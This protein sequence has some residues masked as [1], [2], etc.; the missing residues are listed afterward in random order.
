MRVYEDY[1]AAVLNVLRKHSRLIFLSI[2]FLFFGAK[3]LVSQTDSTK[4]KIKPSGE[5]SNSNN[6]SSNIDLQDPLE[7]TWKYNPKTNQYDAYRQLGTL[8]YA[9]GKSLTITEYF[10]YQSKLEKSKYNR[11][12][13]QNTD[14]SQ[15]ITKG[16]ITDYIQA[17]LSNPAISKIFGEG[18]VDFQL[19]GSAMVKLGGTINEYRN[20]N[21]SK[22]QQRYFVPVFDQ[23]LQIAANGNIGEFVKLG[24]NYDTEAQF[25]FD[26]QTN[27]GWKGKPDGILKDVQVGNVNLNLPTQLIK[28]ANN[29]FGFANTMQFGKT[30]IKTVFSQNRGQSTETVLKGGAQMNEFK[31]SADNYDQNRH[32]FLSQFFRDNYDESLKNL[33]IVASGVIINR[34]EVWVTNRNANVETPRDILCFMDLGEADPYRD[35][36]GGTPGGPSDR[37]AND[38]YNLI[39]NN[40]G[41]RKLGTAVDETYSLFPYF[42]QTVDF[43]VLNY[44]RQLKNTEFTLNQ[45][46]GY[47]S[48]NQPLNND[49]I[50]AVAFEYTYNG[51]TYQVGEFSRDIPP[52]DQRVLHLKMLKGNTIRTQLPIWDLM[53][54]NIYSLNTYSLSLEDFKLNVIYA[55]DT[56]GADYNYLPIGGADVPALSE[57]QPLIRVLGLDKLN[58]QQEA[59]PDGIFDAIEGVT[60]QKKNARVI[61]P[62]VEPFGDFLR[63][64]FNGR[65][66]LADFYCY[67]AVY[68]STKFLAKQDVKHN[69]FFLQGSF[70]SSNGAELFLGTTNLQRG[71]VRVT[72]NGRP[73]QEGMDYE[74]DYAMGR[75]RIINQGLLQGG[76]EI[77]ASADGQSMFNIQQKTLLGG[78]IEHKYSKNLQF[79]GT[80]LHMYERPIT[81]KTNFNEEPLLNTI[82]G[83]DLAYSSKS[84]FLTKLIDKLPF[85]ETKEVSNITAY[86][87]FA[88]IIPHNH[89]SQGG[90][91][92]VSNLEDFE[93][94]ELQNDFKVVSNW[95]VASI[96]QKQPEL[97]PET[98]S[99]DKRTWLNKHAKLSFYT[100]D[101]LFYRDADMPSNIQTRVDE[102][103]SNPYMRQV[104]QR[105]VFPER[106]FPQGTPTILPTLDLAFDPHVRGMYNYNSDPTEIDAT[107]KLINPNKSWAGIMR[108]VDQNDFEAANIDYVEI[109]LMDP[110]MDNPNLK[111]ELLFHLGNV[112]EDILPD[113]RKAFENGLPS[114]AGNGSELDTSQFGF[115][116]TSPQINFAF[117]N[118]PTARNLQDVGLDGMNDEEEK[119]FFDTAYLQKIQSN[120]GNTSPLYLAA[121]QD[122]S[123]DN[124]VHYLENQYTQ[125]DADIIER[126]SRYQGMQ[127]NSSTA[128]FTGQYADMPKS[129]TTQ[130][131]YE[132]I[133]RDFTMNQSEDYYQYRIKIGA[134]D[135]QIGQNYVADIA[136]NTITLRNGQQKE[137]KWY[138]LKIPIREFEKAVGNISDFKSIRFMRM[139]MTGFNDL[140]VLRFGYINMVRADWRRYLNSL[141]TPGLVVPTDP[142]DGTKFVV[143]TVNLEENSKRSPIAY[144]KPPGIE[145]VQNMASL[146]TVLENEQSLSLQTCN[147]QPGDARGAFKT[148]QYDI[149]NYSRMQLYVH[150]EEVTPNTIED[151]EVSVFIRFGTDLTNNY[152]E[153]ELPL[154]MTRGF[155]T[156]TSANSDKLIWPDANFID[157]EF[158]K[159]FNLKVNRQNINW[160]MTAPFTKA[161]EKGK[162]SV[163]GLPDL[164][165]I[166]VMMIGVRNNS[167]EPKCFEVW[168]NELRVK[169]IANSGGW[170]ALANV[171][172]QLADFGQ[173]NMAGSI[174]TIGFGDVDKKLNDRSLTN[175]YN[176]DIATNLEFGK[177]FPAD[178][179]VSIP[180]YLGWSESFIRPKFNPLNP[181]LNLENYLAALSSEAIRESIRK[182]AEDYNSLFS[183]NINNFKFAR[184]GGKK[185]KPWSIS[186]FNGSYSYQSNYRRNQQ[187]EEFFLNTTQATLGY[188]YSN[189]TKFIR[190]FKKIKSKKLK[191]IRDFNFNLLPSSFTSQLQLNRL[192][193]E[194]QARNNNNFKQINP[195]LYDKNFTL[196]RNYNLAFPIARSLNV[197]YLANVEA[198]IQEPY[199]EINSKEKQDS[200]W[201]EF[202]GFGRMRRFYQ[203]T[204]ATYTFPFSKISWLRW[205]NGSATYNGSYE[206]NQAPPAFASLGNTIQNSQD[207][208]VTGQFNLSLLYMKIPWLKDYRKSKRVKIDPEDENYESALDRGKTELKKPNPLTVML[209][210]LITMVKNANVNITRKETT[211]LPGFAHRPDYFGYN[212]YRTEPGI[213]FVFGLQ[214]PNMR[215]NMAN[216]GSLMSD[217]RQANF[218][219]NNITQNISGN[220]TIE[221]LKDFR[222]RINFQRNETRG[223]QSIFKFDGN[224]WLDQGLTE[225]GTYTISGLFLNTHFVKDLDQNENHPNPVFDNFL[226]NRYTVATRLQQQDP[227]VSGGLVIDPA[228]GYP[229]GYSKS[230]QD[231]I[232]GGF[233]AAYSG[234]DVGRSEIGL[235]P[236][237]PMP[238]WSINYN[239]LSRIPGLSDIFSNVNI[240]HSYKG[241]YTVGNYQRNL[242]YDISAIATLGSDLIPKYQ[243]ADV[244]ITEG[245]SPLFGMN[246]TTKN[247]WTL[248]IE[249]KR[250]RVL[251]LFAASFNLTEMRQ[252]EFVMNAGYRVTG[253]T[254]P[255]RRKGRKV[256][257]PNDC[258][259]DLAVTISDNTT[260]IR[261]ID[262]NVNRYTAGMLNVRINP[263]VT[264]QVNQ[265]INLALRYNRT[266]MDPKIATQFYTSLT[267]MGIELRYTFN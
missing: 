249:Y 248:G 18:G 185:P 13:S 196:N 130:P 88:Q 80:A 203:R 261:K 177:F 235:F 157:L 16:G 6:N 171:Q 197:T 189:N 27:L 49:E 22:R 52:G 140:A 169:D 56:S 17:E 255:V 63:S 179:G 237:L 104:D 234:Q 10:Q 118:N 112:S 45:Q 64:Q 128:T 11:T 141:K 158:Q 233:Y 91:R 238:N 178:M 65:N 260:V 139:V 19:T 199:G 3:P 239:G 32:F 125:Q 159:L 70:K 95:T 242:Q 103:L 89:K 137:I 254:L 92:G 213:G 200:I 115:I 135:L 9:T 201:A 74:V 207:I 90:Q 21:Y 2:L 136:S 54:K 153:Y 36:L 231:V 68:D 216:N 111:G 59:K 114:T 83:A 175:N 154:K 215:F 161:I 183:F 266:I 122:P 214:D 143:S 258:R 181:D 47:I 247:N 148:V 165:N 124:F 98:Q 246:I 192:Y 101:Q 97:F 198:R 188:A 236:T 251:K 210:D 219:K 77:R 146:G 66:D 85:L 259:F 72:A 180:V 23:Q 71:S 4:F 217:E 184:P 202:E 151:D 205:I 134:S 208:N 163:L 250:M 110:L 241:T 55:D 109:W 78:R 39:E 30:T 264:Y 50:L 173:L 218:Y 265:K 15:A 102:I 119:D 267:D 221:P 252:N 224:Q 223:T 44:A 133:N 29:L 73:L 225:T 8:S 57:G 129:S 94:A 240:K 100:I 12:K 33:P 222:I 174:R 113:R 156:S 5:S 34:V 96:P 206:W 262:V 93:A 243:V 20:P 168:T 120:F 230:S 228:T 176:Y 145:R 209:G 51:T 147:L 14:Y 105:E 62:V 82:I 53:M 186:N 35:A 164:S 26:N 212:F 256:Y 40:E 7:Y 121:S 38:L 61:F 123:N 107:G 126:Y 58:R 87:E 138:Q 131:D 48:L 263:S 144:V 28:P 1:R 84:R 190:P 41:M 244:T 220:I 253:L 226:A 132:D 25:D 160:P 108:R 182:A 204:N 194:T 150:A 211:E 166:R 46:L 187:I 24:I 170:A 149:R 60:I 167:N 31:I 81:T 193:S 69:K 172:A 76:A 37:Y 155:V 152:Y 86:A 117:D 257:L 43:D 232:I 99:I 42:E 142:N 195:R 229:V 162:I 106:N 191:L 79:G 116:S 75:V 67:T 245:F 227:R 127:G